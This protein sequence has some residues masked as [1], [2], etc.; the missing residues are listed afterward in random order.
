M[1]A[2]SVASSAGFAETPPHSFDDAVEFRRTFG[3][4]ADEDLVRRSLAQPGQFPDTDWGVPLSSE[5]AADLHDRVAMR[6]AAAD[7]ISWAYAQRDH[8][9][10]WIDQRDGGRIIFQFAG[11]L[12]EAEDRLAALLPSQTR[13]EVRRV[14]HSLGDLTQLADAIG[15]ESDDLVGQGVDLSAIGPDIRQNE[16][17]V[18]VLEQADRA[19]SILAD[20]F[21][22]GIRVLRD[23]L[24]VADAC[25]ILDC[26]K[27]KGGLA[28]IYQG[29]S[30]GAVVCSAGYVA[31]RYDDPA[32]HD[33]LAVVTAG[34]CLH[35]NGGGGVTWKLKDGT[36]IGVSSPKYV[37]EDEADADIGFIRIRYP[38]DEA[39]Q[40]GNKNRVMLEGYSPGTYDSITSTRG[41]RATGPPPYDIQIV[42]DPVCRVGWGSHKLQLTNAKCG[43][44]W[45][46]DQKKK[47]TLSGYPAVWVRHL[48]VASFDSHP[49]DSGGTMFAPNKGAGNKRLLGTHVHSNNDDLP[50]PEWAEGTRRGWYTP[51]DWGLYALEHHDAYG[52]LLVPCK[53]AGC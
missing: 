9:G 43:E 14:D 41:A 50:P 29:A 5:E 35:G 52:V 39:C 7:A 38:A 15:A 33:E 12:V 20:R 40:P 28:I 8:A 42:G 25:N 3:L 10:V 6:E 22:P 17:R 4:N 34:H 23:A 37:W 49:G 2:I 53:T 45:L 48:N 26:P 36:C 51:Y 11:S 27:V 13:Y 19:A 18:G 46:T 30:S 1:L 31:R 44:I 32:P 21:G 47:S 16:V 24:A